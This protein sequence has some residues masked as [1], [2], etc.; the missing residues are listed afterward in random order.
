MRRKHVLAN[1]AL[2]F[3]SFGFLGYIIIVIAGYL[4]CCA[5]I[6]ETLYHN[7]VIIILVIAFALFAICMYN[8]CCK[9][10]I[11]KDTEKKEE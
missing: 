5:N 10:K 3:G 8:N 1:F 7:L 2:L 11:P 4:G 6:N 9:V